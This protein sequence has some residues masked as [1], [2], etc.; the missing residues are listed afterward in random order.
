MPAV[1]ELG[2]L[3]PDVDGT[4]LLPQAVS[5]GY[6]RQPL[7]VTASPEFSRWGQTFGDEQMAAAV[8]DRVVHHGRLIGFRGESCRVRRA[9]M[10]GEGGSPEIVTARLNFLRRR[11]LSFA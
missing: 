8:T 11:W 6:E 4:R 10:R 3:P 2:F 7:A 5:E 1:D 9:L